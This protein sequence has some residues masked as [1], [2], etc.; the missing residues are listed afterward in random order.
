MEDK[1]IHG[2]ETETLEEQATPSQQF[3]DNLFATAQTEVPVEPVVGKVSNPKKHLTII[4]ILIIVILAIAGA[5]TWALMHN[6]KPVDTAAP[7]DTTAAQ[8]TLVF[9]VHWVEDY[10]INGV[11]KD[12]QLV[13][14]GLSQYLDEYNQLHPN[15]K[16]VAQ[17]IEYS[18]YAD[19]LKIFDESG[20]GPD[21]YQIYSPWGASY[22]RANMLDTPPDDVQKDI[23]QNYVSY[24]GATIDNK[25]WGFPTEVNNYA[26]LYNKDLLK[27]AGLVDTKGN[28]VAPKTWKDV[29]TYASKLTKKDANGN[30]TQYGIAF[31]KDNDWQ[32]VDP[33][34]SLLF[35]NGGSYLSSDLKH[36]TFNS[37]AGI[38]ALEAELQLFKNGSTDIHGNSGDF[39]TGKVAMIIS[40]PWQ[41]SALAE[42][43]GDKFS[44]SV[45]VAPFPYMSTPA[46]LQYSWF[47][48]VMNKSQ[49]KQ[50]AWDFLKWFTTET[51]SSGTTRYGDLLAN[52]IGAIPA[53]K[54]DFTTHKD[55][56]GDFFTSTYVDQMNVSTAEPNV[57]QAS[58]IKAILMTEIQAAWAGQKTAKQALDSAATN[59]DEILSQYY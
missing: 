20:A 15:V 36:A 21:M 28:P 35:S 22:V 56:L 10:Q 17:Q 9:A 1:N 45:G 43:F 50:E 27:E 25:I 12:G 59:I 44:S 51:Q 24:V 29:Q 49:H 8:T 11:T 18:Q 31:L 40:P 34:L 52:T 48:G 57:M 13:S 47:M 55:A 6:N 46:T 14:K 16:V 3:G 39:G 41:K 58:Q 5:V 37:V 26:L 7:S 23:K 32:V 54:V 19:K 4:S 38:A 53:R 2:D 42:S 33:F 30:I